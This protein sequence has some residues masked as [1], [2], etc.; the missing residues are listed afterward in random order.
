MSAAVTL[1]PSRAIS[2]LGSTAF[3]AALATSPRSKVPLAKSRDAETTSKS[4]IVADAMTGS[5]VPR[6]IGKRFQTLASPL[7]V[8]S[9]RAWPVAMGSKGT[10]S[11]TITGAV[12]AISVMRSIVAS[13]VTS[14]MSGWGDSDRSPYCSAIALA[15]GGRSTPE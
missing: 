2:A 11:R 8:P 1:T 6:E 15:D 14:G 13:S 12:P 3:T 4:A 9:R 7:T 10:G 5:S